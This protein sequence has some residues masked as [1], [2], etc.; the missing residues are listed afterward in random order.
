MSRV[1]YS[2]QQL[3]Q[4]GELAASGGS[5]SVPAGLSQFPAVAPNVRLI[6]ELK[7]TGFVDRQWLVQRDGRLLGR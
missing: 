2:R 6:G 1:K 5:A 4:H 7:D 3:D